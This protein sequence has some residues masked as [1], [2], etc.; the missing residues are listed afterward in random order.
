MRG[1]K[2]DLS[3]TAVVTVI[4]ALANVGLF[5][6]AARIFSQTDFAYYALARRVL[7]TILPAVLIGMG[8]ALPRFVS[9]YGDNRNISRIVKYTIICLIISN[10]ILYLIFIIWKNKISEIAF[11]SYGQIDLVWSIYAAIIGASVHAVAYGYLRG[12]LEIL[13]ANSLN[14]ICLGVIPLV[15]VLLSF[16]SVE[17]TFVTQGILIAVVD[18]PVLAYYLYY[19]SE[20]ESVDSDSISLQKY[21]AYGLSRVPGDFA[22]MALLALP[23]I[24][25]VREYGVAVGGA[26]AFG[27]TVVTMFGMALSPVSTL[28]LPY[29]AKS[30]ASP[31]FRAELPHKINRFTLIYIGVAT[32]LCGIF[33]ITHKFIIR[34]YI[35]SA[36]GGYEPI[37]GIMAW[38]GIGYGLY[39]GLRS[40]VDAVHEKAYNSIS[41][42]VS[43]LVFVSLSYAIVRY[44][45]AVEY[46]IASFGVSTLVLGILTYI[47]SVKQ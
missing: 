43:A 2:A 21:L 20:G 41:S 13:P 24:L 12:R 6:I 14:A 8:V 26:V 47:Y 25:A 19:R 29:I 33:Y 35:G 34:V 31:I 42:I 18:A 11:G 5:A 36:L 30:V 3:S 23:A 15:S 38:A 1:F 16:G 40:V 37:V 17:R 4:I 44:D 32:F 46:M 28:V 9:R 22:L 39:V 45:G 7:A 10:L 27:S